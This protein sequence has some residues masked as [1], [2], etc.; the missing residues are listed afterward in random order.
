MDR[1]DINIPFIAYE[2]GMD[3]QERANRRLWILCIILSL[4]LIGTNIGWI[5]YQSQFEHVV[6]EIEAE[7]DGDVNIVGG[8][9]IAYGAENKD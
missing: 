5:C 7:Q 9:D 4:L 2:S 3:R 8:G 6:T 1:T